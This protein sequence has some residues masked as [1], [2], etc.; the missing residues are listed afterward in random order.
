MQPSQTAYFQ[1]ARQM[2]LASR[3][4]ALVELRRL[5]DQ[6]DPHRYVMMDVLS[7]AST[8]INHDPH[9]FFTWVE[10]GFPKLFLDFASD[11]SIYPAAGAT[12]DT[13]AEVHNIS[14]VEDSGLTYHYFRYTCVRPCGR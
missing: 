6:R 1:H 14:V 3:R 10:E 5:H 2:V 11:K 8:P 9:A 4:E 7:A 12:T 13:Q